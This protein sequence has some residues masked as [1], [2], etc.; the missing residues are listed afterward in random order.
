MVQL[1]SLAGQFMSNDSSNRTFCNDGNALYLHWPIWQPLALV[2]TSH[3]PLVY[4]KIKFLILSNHMYL[5]A[6]VSHKTISEYWA[7][8]CN[9]MWA[10]PPRTTRHS[11]QVQIHSHK[12]LSD[13]SSHIHHHYYSSPT[14]ATSKEHPL[15]L[16][17]GNQVEW[18]H[19]THTTAEPLSKP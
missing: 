11:Q 19:E 8:S 10:E 4:Q 6:T 17:G 14:L 7:K 5:I 2:A 1:T 13:T 9:R 16:I 12:I 18:P 3:Q 15:S